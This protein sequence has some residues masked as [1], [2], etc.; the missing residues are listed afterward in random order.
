M[1]SWFPYSILVRSIAKGA[2]KTKYAYD[3]LYN[4]AAKLSKSEIIDIMNKTY[5]GLL[6]KKEIVKFDFP[7]L[8]VVGDSDNT[9]NV[10]KYNQKW[11]K[12]D[13]YPLKV[14]TYAAHNSNVD[15]YE[16]FNQITTDFL[17]NL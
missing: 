1:S 8:L 6:E 9:G 7:V 14:I 12:H 3:N 16:E 11:A 2:T 15:N 5:D 17:N 10:K 13:G 4:S